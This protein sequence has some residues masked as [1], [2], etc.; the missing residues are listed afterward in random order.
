M[1]VKV[2]SLQCLIAS[3]LISWLISA[4]TGLLPAQEPSSG[5]HA[6]QLKEIQDAEDEWRPTSAEILEVQLFLLELGFD[7]GLP[8]GT[9]GR[10]T[11]AA[12]EAFQRA[13]K[14]EADG[15]LTKDFYERLTK[16]YVESNPSSALTTSPVITEQPAPVD[17]QAQ[18]PGRDCTL[19]PN[20]VWL[21]EDSFGGK[22]TMALQEDGSVE[23]PIYPDHWRWQ[24]DGQDIEIKYD[25]H[26]GMTVS[27]RGH[28]EGSS[29]M[30]GEAVDSRERSWTWRAERLQ[31]SPDDPNR[32]CLPRV[33][34]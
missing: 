31:P 5:V 16:E 15:K 30:V 24:A 26:M 20:S 28:L 21:F 23:G 33:S 29:L 7:P 34:Q 22:F 3:I 19:I 25:N 6:A 27:R 17:S 11:I 10:R 8:D 13:N 32:E 12:I 4:Q 18:K 14:I 1:E 2:R 9:M